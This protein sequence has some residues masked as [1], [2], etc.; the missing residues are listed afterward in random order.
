[1]CKV[2]FLNSV[3]FLRCDLKLKKKKNNNNKKM[4][5][6]FYNFNSVHFKTDHRNA[7]AAKE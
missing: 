4:K 2:L 5:M 6:N 3:R 7:C 1:M